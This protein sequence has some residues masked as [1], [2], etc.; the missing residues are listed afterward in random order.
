MTQPVTAMGT[1]CWAHHHRELVP[2]EVHHVWP[3]GDGGPNVAFNKIPLCSNAHSA[4]HDLLD[5]LRKGNVPWTVRR[6]YGR[7]VRR[8]AEAGYTAIAERRIVPLI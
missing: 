4:A 6:R 8:V 1:S 5:K 3:V 2:I 7:K